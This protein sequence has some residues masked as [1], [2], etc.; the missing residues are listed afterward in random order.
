V[1][2]LP[3]YRNQ[4][5]GRFLTEKWCHPLAREIIDKI[6]FIMDSEGNETG[7]WT[8]KEDEQVQDIINEYMGCKLDFENM[9]LLKFDTQERVHK[10][11]EEASVQSFRAALG[12]KGN[13]NN[14]QEDSGVPG[15]SLATTT[16]FQGAGSGAVPV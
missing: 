15:A 4:I 3:A 16:D 2:I 10:E 14:N 6:T 9:E 8:T 13:L 1:D 12:A 11:A 7:E 5:Y